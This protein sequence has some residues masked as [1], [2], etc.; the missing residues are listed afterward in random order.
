MEKNAGNDFSKPV[1]S[2]V[3]AINL[4]NTFQTGI[5][6]QSIRLD[7]PIRKDCNPCLPCINRK[8]ILKDVNL[9]KMSMM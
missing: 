3:I 7:I 2:K 1:F 8:G 4:P 5:L 9:E 6:L